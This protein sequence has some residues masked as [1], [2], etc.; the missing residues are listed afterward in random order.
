M[1][2][3]RPDYSTCE[4]FTLLLKIDTPSHNKHD[5]MIACTWGRNRTTTQ[6]LTQV[7]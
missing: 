6:G 1:L 7:Y 3:E 5:A 4:G 2:E